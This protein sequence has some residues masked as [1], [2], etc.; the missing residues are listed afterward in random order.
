M[1]TEK[2]RQADRI[3]LLVWDRDRLWICYGYMVY[4]DENVS[5]GGERSHCMA[6]VREIQLDI[7]IILDFSIFISLLLIR[8]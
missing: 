6:H 2:E 7:Q 1:S 4:D 8:H 5:K 3:K